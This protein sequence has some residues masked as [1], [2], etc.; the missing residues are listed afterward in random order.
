[1]AFL[2]RRP[3]DLLTRDTP[4]RQ[5]QKARNAAQL[6]ETV[7]AQRLASDRQRDVP[8]RFRALDADAELR[9][10]Q[11][12]ATAKADEP[13]GSTGT[14]IGRVLPAFGRAA[15]GLCIVNPKLWE[16][17][18]RPLRGRK[19]DRDAWF[20]RVR[21]AAKTREAGDVL[22]PILVRLA[23]VMWWA[24]RKDGVGFARQTFEQFGKLAG[25]CKETARKG[26]RFLER[27]G[28]VDTFNVLTRAH[29]FVRRVAN[30]YLIRGDTT[31]PD[32]PAGYERSPSDSLLGRLTRYASL[33]GLRARAWGLNATP[34]PVGYRSRPERPVPS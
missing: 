6:A 14:P 27:H 31:E 33:F 23:E 2:P 34:A 5:A 13:L 16:A 21:L 15:A 26:I 18:V 1:V 3:P 24:E 22:Q 7:A 32:P 11:A 9:A 8:L 19:V 10:V 12:A 25:C 4:F 20:V 17:D 28:L 29:G 30:L